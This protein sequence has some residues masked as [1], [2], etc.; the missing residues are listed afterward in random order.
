MDTYL[1]LTTSYVYQVDAAKALQADLGLRPSICVGKEPVLG[2][3]AESFPECVTLSR[4]ELLE[5]GQAET[6]VTWSEFEQLNDYWDSSAYHLYRLNLL[7]QFNRYPRLRNIRT[8]DR[9]VALRRIQLKAISA[10]LAAQ[11]DFVLSLDV[12]HNPVNL[13]ILH[14]AESLGIP[15]LTFVSA[16][17][18]AP[19]MVPVGGIRDDFR[20]LPIDFPPKKMEAEHIA[21]FIKR[22]AQ[23][24]MASIVSSQEVSWQE[25]ERRRVERVAPRK[26]DK[27][28]EL[29]YQVLTSSKRLLRP[30]DAALDSL[31]NFWY[32]D[33]FARHSDLPRTKRSEE[34]GL[35]ALQ[36]EPEAM[37]VPLG[38]VETSQIDAVR[39]ARNLLPEHIHLIVKE[40]PSQ[41]KRSMEGALGRSGEFYDLISSIPNTTML[42]GFADTGDLMKKSKVVFTLTGS[43][44]F[45]ASL[46]GIPVVYFGS[47]WWEGAPGTTHVR[48]IDGVISS[49]V[50]EG[51]PNIGVEEFY[52]ERLT[53]GSILGF[54][55]A[56]SYE[57]WKS[58]PGLPEGFEEAAQESLVWVVHEF[59]QN[60]AGDKT[61]QGIDVFG[62][63]ILARKARFNFHRGTQ[64]RP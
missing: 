61:T 21:E 26:M 10:I 20:R 38:I 15:A 56:G 17:I 35:F 62:G 53:R 49:T 23:N 9:E 29:K 34:F 45:E 3:L 12:P 30:S 63:D 4:D 37:S 8:L 22:N 31:I 24:S 6:S 25:V 39:Q 16:G 52:I 27:L 7:E 33:L 47:P 60:L 54:G 44:G 13:A 41:L 14:L 36:F 55:D 58:G 2:V 28:R 59:L 43:I 32:E 5:Q 50:L 40:H 18:V 11:P 46:L 64:Q 42:S 57:T 48:D 19:V 1:F 51:K